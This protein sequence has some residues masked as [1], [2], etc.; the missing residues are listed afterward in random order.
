MLEIIKKNSVLFSLFLRNL[1][2]FYDMFT[3]FSH[4]FFY[5]ICAWVEQFGKEMG[6]GVLDFYA[7]ILQQ[8]CKISL[9]ENLRIFGMKPFKFQLFSVSLRGAESL[10]KIKTLEK[11]MWIGRI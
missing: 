4:F 11:F 10:R 2:F 7:G 1:W 8:T 6:G 5:S 9:E 3:V